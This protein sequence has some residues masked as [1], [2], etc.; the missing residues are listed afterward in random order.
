MKGKKL[1]WHKLSDSIEGMNWG[2]NNMTVVEVAGK[3]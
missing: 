2:K 1:K 3:K